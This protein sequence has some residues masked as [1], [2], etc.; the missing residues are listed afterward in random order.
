MICCGSNSLRRTTP[1][2][3][4]KGPSGGSSEGQLIRLGPPQ[5]LT[6]V[7]VD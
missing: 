2:R 3:D 5:I 7:F 6:L 4:E 1:G